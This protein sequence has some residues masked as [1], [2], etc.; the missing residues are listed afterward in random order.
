MLQTWLKSTCS[1]CAPASIG[2][3]RA[4]PLAINGLVF[5]GYRLL[6]IHAQTL[7]ICIRQYWGISSSLVNNQRAGGFYRGS[8]FPLPNQ[9]LSRG[10]WTHKRVEVIRQSNLGA[11]VIN[12]PVVFVEDLVYSSLPINDLSQ[13]L[14]RGNLDTSVS[15]QRDYSFYWRFVIPPWLG[16]GLRGTLTGPSEYY[17]GII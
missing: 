7:W 13:I 10:I 14:Q 5:A 6:L 9:W 2:V 17:G 4:L 16:R 11:L 12:R 1:G 3:I 15:N 8:C